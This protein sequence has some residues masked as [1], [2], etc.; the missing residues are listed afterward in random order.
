MK[1]DQA[2]EI[3]GGL[4]APSKM[5]CYSFNIPAKKCITGAKLRKIKGTTCSICYALKGRY[6]FPNVENA[7]MRRFER[8]SDPKWIEA[9][10]F[11]ITKVEKSAYFRWFDSG[12][13]QSV[14]H[15]DNIVQVAKNTPYITHWLPTREYSFVSEYLASGKVFPSNL[16][17]RIS[18]YFMNGAPPTTIANRLGVVTSGVNKDSYNCPAPNQ[19]NKCLNCRACWDKNVDNVS[20]KPH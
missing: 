10:S 9:M 8:L 12:D 15:L 2:I 4:S 7:L 16:T 20:Y 14:S 17:V 13:I 1:K 5:P 11:L 6:R 18:A 3:T 19:D